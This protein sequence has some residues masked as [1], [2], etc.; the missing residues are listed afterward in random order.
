[1][2]EYLAA[3]ERVAQ[4]LHLRGS[5]VTVDANDLRLLLAGPPVSREDVARVIGAHVRKDFGT[6]TVFINALADAI[7]ALYREG[8]P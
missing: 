7:Q 8:R 6:L 1:M 4:L 2:T 3:R 5:R